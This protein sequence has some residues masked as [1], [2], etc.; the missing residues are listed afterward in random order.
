MMKSMSD[1]VHEGLRALLQP[2]DWALDATLG[3]GHDAELIIEC[4]GEAGQVWGLDIQA[5][6]IASAQ[7]RLGSTKAILAIEC[8]HAQMGEHL[9]A[10]ARGRLKAIVFNLGYLP[11]GDHQITTQIQSTLAALDIAFEWLAPEG[12]LICTCYPGHSEGQVEAEAITAWFEEQAQ[13]PGHLT[14][15]EQLCTR[16]PAPFVLWMERRLAPRP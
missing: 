15:I 11:G 6:A 13:S 3:N 2:G 5:S 7:Q 14:R 8:D 9:P 12:A 1:W 10:E 16:A 4:V